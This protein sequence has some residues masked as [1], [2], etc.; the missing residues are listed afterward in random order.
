VPMIPLS[1]YGGVNDTADSAMQTLFKSSPVSMTPLYPRTSDVNVHKTN[2]FLRPNF[3]F[4]SISKLNVI[5]YSWL[6]KNEREIK[7]I[8][9]KKFVCVNVQKTKH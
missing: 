3:Q 5:I 8:L 7:H 4:V 6:V 1:K 2:S 9:F